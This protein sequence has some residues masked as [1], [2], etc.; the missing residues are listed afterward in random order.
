MKEEKLFFGQQKKKV[1]LVLWSSN[2]GG[3]EVLMPDI[4]NNSTHIEY[5]C[6]ILNPPGENDIFKNFEVLDSVYPHANA[7]SC[8]CA[9]HC[10]SSRTE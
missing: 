8:Y 10:P 6:F 9:I 7:S 5:E 4:V 3:I 2:P 1:L